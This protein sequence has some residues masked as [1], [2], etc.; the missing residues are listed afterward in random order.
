MPV[1]Y[2]ICAMSASAA[3]QQARQIPRVKHHSRSA[4]LEVEEISREKSLEIIN[5]NRND[6]YLQCNS[7]QTQRSMITYDDLINRLVPEQSVLSHDEEDRIDGKISI[8]AGKKRLRKPQR[9]FKYSF[10]SCS[11]SRVINL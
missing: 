11:L 6:P 1:V 4:I 9:Y 8:Y 3:A 10:D 7:I 5:A 2:A